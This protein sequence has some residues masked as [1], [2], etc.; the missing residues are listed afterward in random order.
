MR[1]VLT[2]ILWFFLGLIVTWIATVAIGIV[3]MELAGTSQAEG[4]AAMG[5]V[6][7]IGPT[8]GIV[9]AIVAAIYGVSRRAR[10]LR[11]ETTP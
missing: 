5:L 3:Y 9:G 2:A 4:A 7:I 6:F 1:A 10:R 11:A 8:V